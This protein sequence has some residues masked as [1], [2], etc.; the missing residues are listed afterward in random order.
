MRPAETEV[1][2]DTTGGCT[3]DVR[4]TYSTQVAFNTAKPAEF[5]IPSSNVIGRESDLIILTNK[6]NL[7]KSC[8]Q[9]DWALKTEQA[10]QLYD[11]QT[12]VKRARESVKT[13]KKAVDEA[14]ERATLLEDPYSKTTWWETWFP[15]GRP[16]KKDNVPVLMGIS[17]FFLIFA[18]G[19][20]LRLSAIELQFVPVGTVS[21]NTGSGLTNLFARKSS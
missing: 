18:L 19:L 8:I 20:F 10:S 1:R 14:K 3:N 16:M 12:E 17:V 6:I 15:L 5:P 2:F 9:R 4:Q 11:A 13:T 7:Y 21:S